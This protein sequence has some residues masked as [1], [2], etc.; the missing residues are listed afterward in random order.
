MQIDGVEIEKGSK[1]SWTLDAGETVL[2]KFGVPVTVI[3]GAKDGPTLAVMAGCHPGE[4][5][6]ITAAIKLSNE[7]DPRNLAGSLIIVHVQNPLGLQFKKAYVNPL[8]GI[9][10]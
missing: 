4:L 9:N 2:G 1:K 10:F 7:I 5:V 6:A 8:D 3:N